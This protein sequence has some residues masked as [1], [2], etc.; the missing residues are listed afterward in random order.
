MIDLGAVA[1][2]TADHGMSDKCREDGTPNVIYLEDELNSRFGTGAVRVICP[3]TDPFVK[4][5]GGLW[6]LKLACVR[7]EQYP[8]S[9]CP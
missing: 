7:M 5:H 3:I 6:S 2:S 1:G 4:H 9:A 8:S